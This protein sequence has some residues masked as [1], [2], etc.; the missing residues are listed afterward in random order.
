[1]II[2]HANNLLHFHD[3]SEENI[4]ESRI[5]DNPIEAVMR[6]LNFIKRKLNYT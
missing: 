5:S 2:G 6:F 3:R 1:M 4:K